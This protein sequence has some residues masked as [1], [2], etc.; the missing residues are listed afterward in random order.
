MQIPLGTGIGKYSEHLANALSKEAGISVDILG[1]SP[2]GAGRKSARLSYLRYINSSAFRRKA[3][4]YD[5]CIFTNYAMPFRKL[6]TSTAVTVHDLAVYDYPETLP[7]TY[8]PY[9]RLMI[10]NSV[11]KAD[12]IITVSHTMELAISERY[13]F[14]AAKVSY[15]WPGVYSHVGVSDCGNPYDDERLEEVAN[16]PFFLMMG[17]VEKRKNVEFVI[18]AFAQFKKLGND[19]RDHRLVLAGRPGFGFEDIDAR[20]AESGVRDSIVFTGYA[21]DNDCRNLYRDAIAQIFPSV[22]EGFGSTQIESMV[23][24]LPILL[25]DIPTNREVS[26]GFGVFFKLGK[27]NSLAKAMMEVR[28][29]TPLQHEVARGVLNRADWRSVAARY[30]HT[31]QKPDTLSSEDLRNVYSRNLGCESGELK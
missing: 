6:E 19:S 31:M 16:H 18:D 12:A 10:E 5:L 21:T 25:S 17:T 8:V 30:L 1:F 13:P 3:E 2:R 9:G 24:G 20:A 26:D 27:V 23:M 22:Y 11:R 28:G 15:A 4:G 14:A 7:K 29:L